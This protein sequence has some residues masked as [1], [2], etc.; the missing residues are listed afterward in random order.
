MTLKQILFAMLFNALFLGA[1]VGGLSHR[2]GHLSGT[3]MVYLLLHCFCIA[4]VGAVI[5][6][7]WYESIRETNA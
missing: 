2:E 5:V 6:A 1:V 7:R 3:G 4:V